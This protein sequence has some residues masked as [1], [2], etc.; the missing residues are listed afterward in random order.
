M[1]PSTHVLVAIAATIL[2]LVYSPHLHKTETYVKLH[3][4]DTT[5][6]FTPLGHLCSAHRLLSNL[7][8]ATPDLTPTLF[9][10]LNLDPFSHPFF[11]ASDCAYPHSKNHDEARDRTMAAWEAISAEDNGWTSD[12]RDAVAVV[13]A[14]LLDDTAR[15]VY[16]R[17][18]LP[19]IQKTGW[20]D[21]CENGG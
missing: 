15:T 12:W 2:C 16:L 21:V 17:E 20:R 9:D 10:V 19:K 5:A 13:A 6:P 3:A 1:F 7:Q 11:P 4:L 18:V 8:A 14:T